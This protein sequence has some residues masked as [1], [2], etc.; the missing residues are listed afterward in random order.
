[1]RALIRLMTV[2][3]EKRDIAWLTEALQ[4]AIQ[5]EMS[6]IPPYL[7]AE[8][9]IDLSSPV[10]DPAGPDPAGVQAAISQIVQEEMLHMGIACNM[11]ASIGGHPQI[12][13][14]A[15]QYPAQLPVNIHAGLE[16]GL[17]PLTRELVLNKFMAI[18]EPVEHLFD[19]PDFTPSG[20]RLIG[21][22]YDDLFK[23]FARL[24]PP[25]SA[26]GQVD[27]SDAFGSADAPAPFGNSLI[28]QSLDDVQA[29]IALITRQ[30]EG[31]DA[32]PFES[33]DHP[34]ELAHF[35][36]FGEIYHGHRLNPT[37]PFGYTGDEVK[38]PPVHMVTPADNTVSAGFNQAYTSVLRDLGQ[39]WNGGP[40]DLLTIAFVSMPALRQ[41]GGVLFQGGAGPAFVTV[42]ESGAPLD[43]PAAGNQVARVSNEAD[44]AAG[45][46]PARVS[47][48][49]GAFR[50]DPSVHIAYFRDL[51]NWSNFQRTPDVNAAINVTFGFYDS[52][53]AFAGDA[54]KEQAWIGSLSGPQVRPAVVMLS[55]RQQQTVEAHYGVPVPLLTLLD[56]FERFGSDTLPDDPDRPAAPRH[57]MNAAVM[58]FILSAFA[59]ACMRLEISTEFWVYYMRAILCGLLNDGLIRGRLT[60]K[61][62]EATPEGQLAVLQHVQAVADADLPAEL[63][64]RYVESPLPT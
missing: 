14:K 11:L 21:Q 23:T 52:W 49:T 29:A 4:A 47:L 32:G 9:S 57:N 15:P 38:M 13:E 63:R 35:Y 26:A 39:L 43:P 41:A 18:E 58:W 33:K 31:T 61:G 48:T 28:V 7:Y 64:R 34:G 30:G 53:R 50:P 55:D 17:A 62:F 56:G 19:D 42:D 5:L 46:P 8:W 51:D 27:L 60:V 54:S 59:E 12:L 37:S 25:I 45:A 1:M 6:T 44:V 10:T 24:S 2:P 36:R 22:F 40:A 3:A 16:V 20:S